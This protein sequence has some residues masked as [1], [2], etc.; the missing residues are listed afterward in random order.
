MNGMTPIRRGRRLGIF[1]RTAGVHQPQC[2][3]ALRTADCVGIADRFVVD[4]GAELVVCS[5]TKT[6]RNQGI[7]L[8]VQAAVR[9][10]KSKGK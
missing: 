9:W 5:R 3:C 6:E 8:L 10:T 7:A 1:H 2:M 4:S